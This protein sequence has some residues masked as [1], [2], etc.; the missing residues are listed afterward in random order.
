MKKQTS[1]NISRISFKG[2]TQK[3]DETFVRGYAKREGASPLQSMEN[4]IFEREYHHINGESKH[5]VANAEKRKYLE[6]PSHRT[7][8][9]IL[10]HTER[11]SSPRIIA[12]RRDELE[13]EL[14]WESSE[15]SRINACARIQARQQSFSSSSSQKLQHQNGKGFVTIEVRS[16]P[17][18]PVLEF[19]QNQRKETIDRLLHLELPLSEAAEAESTMP[20]KER[21]NAKTPPAKDIRSD[22]ASLCSRRNMTRQS[23]P[24]PRRSM[25]NKK[26]ESLCQKTKQVDTKMKE[27]RNHP[28]TLPR[29]INFIGDVS[30][31]SPIPRPS[32]GSCCFAMHATKLDDSPGKH[33]LFDAPNFNDSTEEKNVGLDEGYA[34]VPN[35][36]KQNTTDHDEEVKRYLQH[37]VQEDESNT[38]SPSKALQY[39]ITIDS[40]KQKTIDLKWTLRQMQSENGHEEIFAQY[41]R[42]IQGLK[43]ELKVLRKRNIELEMK[44]QLPRRNVKYPLETE[45]KQN[46]PNLSRISLEGLTRRYNTKSRVLNT[47]NVELNKEK[48]K[49]KELQNENNYLRKLLQLKLN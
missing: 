36:R 12:E 1:P 37:K 49:R 3:K 14:L 15:I 41:E 23:S 17:D 30:P 13:N 29:R 27:K 31:A 5:V 21:Q 8:L 9:S 38:I 16:T 11:I 24:P 10:Q 22:N 33:L 45:K 40:L 20:L 19:E 46:S 42:Q 47:I 7:R 18:T 44:I 43:N 48:L 28:N 6:E 35:C 2:L 32:S 25:R 4:R 26:T 39:E 34:S